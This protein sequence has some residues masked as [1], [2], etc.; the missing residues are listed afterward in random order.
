MSGE[1]PLPRAP[2]APRPAATVVLV[3]DAAPAGIEVLLVQRHGSIGFMGGM[4]VFPG[5]KLCTADASSDMHARVADAELVRAQRWGEQLDANACLAR[6]VAATRETFEEAGV[7][8]GAS[9][10]HIAGALADTAPRQPPVAALARMRARLLAGEPFASLLEEHALVLRLSELVPLSRWITPESEPVRFDTSF[11]LA[12]A[13]E[14][15]HALHDDSEAVASLW[16]TPVGALD[17]AQRG[18]IRLAPPTAR[19]L[20]S[21]ADAS[22]VEALASLIQK[23]PPP[24]VEPVIRPVGDELVILYPGDPEHPVQ[25]Q[26]LPGPTRRVLR[27]L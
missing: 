8:L 11:Y 16:A 4:H 12:R 23:R 9:A 2:V 27:K 15:Q 3:R 25:T 5:G 7:L 14:E 1:A 22:S 26:V 18:S 10:E 21:I 20:E 13:P 17:A 19:T 6:A 24:L